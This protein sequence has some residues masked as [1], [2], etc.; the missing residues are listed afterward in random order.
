MTLSELKKSLT[1]MQTSSTSLMVSMAMINN[2]IAS[3]I[4]AIENAD[5]DGI[6]N[7]IAELGKSSKLMADSLEAYCDASVVFLRGDLLD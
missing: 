1:R 4:C 2:D 6:V 7:S 5:D 3:L